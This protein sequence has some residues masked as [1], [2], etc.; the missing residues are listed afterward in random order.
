M[1]HHERSKPRTFFEALH[2][3]PFFF[4]TVFSFG[5][6]LIFLIGALGGF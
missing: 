4:R 1:T 5:A 6:L 3:A 2:D